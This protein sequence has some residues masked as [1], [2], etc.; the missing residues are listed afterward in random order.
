MFVRKAT[1]RL[2]WAVFLLFLLAACAASSAAQDTSP[3]MPTGKTIP[4]KSG[5]YELPETQ[6]APHCPSDPA[7]QGTSGCKSV[8]EAWNGGIA[9]TKRNRLIIWGGGHNDY[10]GN[11]VY[12]LDLNN[13]TMSRL[14]DPS[15]VTNLASCP[16]AYSDGRPSSRHTYNGLAYMS[17]LDK[18][19]IYGGGKSDCG[20]L[21]TGTWTLDVDRLQ[22]ASMDP[23]DG[24]TP[25][26]TP[27]V[28]ADYD[29]NSGV[30]FLSDRTNFLR[31]DPVK[32]TYTRLH[33]LPD[34]DYHLTGVIDSG[35]KLFFMMGGPGQLWVIDIKPGSKY[36]PQDWSHATHGCD[37]LS[38]APYPGLAY[39]PERQVIVGWAGGDTV[40]V[41]NP[42]TKTCTS[43]TYP[44]GPG[45]A[46]PNGTLGRF[47]YFPA[48]GV[49]SIVNDWKQNAFTL[50][51]SSS[52]GRLKSDGE[53]Q[54]AS[55][56]VQ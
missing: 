24:D 40:Y 30:V 52:A 29:P 9:D 18:M 44:G 50:R 42:D 22:W 6:L 11:E 16:E 48:L 28:V 13:L 5:W 2:S 15:P 1:S 25:A 46:Q 21:S 33:S 7:I 51:L 37:A 17:R 10:F 4:Q 31:Y 49:F 35:R 47:R 8:I 54:L 14:N 39:V 41:F 38:K 55:A 3:A 32:N 53:N 19:F 27:G 34:V 56:T 45:P 26:N 20:F 43:E 36:A 12:A 23:H